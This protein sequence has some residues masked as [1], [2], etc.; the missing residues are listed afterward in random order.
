MGFSPNIVNL[1]SVALICLLPAVV[2]L[3]WRQGRPGPDGWGRVEMISIP[4]NL[5]A[6]ALVLFFVFQGQ[7][8]RAVAETVTVTDENGETVERTVVNGA[9]RRH[10]MLFYL[11]NEGPAGD[12]WLRQGFTVAIGTDL[13]QNPGLDTEQPLQRVADL[14]QMGFETGLDLPRPLQRKIAQDAHAPFF[15]AG[16]FRREGQDL[17]VNIVLHDTDKGTILAEHQASGPDFFAL[18]DGITV[19]LMDHLDLPAY[20]LETIPDQPVAD[21]TTDNLEAFREFVQAIVLITHEGRWEEAGDAIKRAVELDPTFALAHFMAFGIHFTNGDVEAAETASQE[22]MKHLYRVSERSQYQIKALYYHNVKSDPDKSMA[23]LEMWE[24]LYPYDVAAQMQ[25]VQFATM[26]G[27][28][29]RALVAY[30]RILEI[31]PS[32]HQFLQEAANLLR[33]EGRFA[34]AEEK[35]LRYAELYPG[36]VRSYARLVDLYEDMGELDKA[37]E[38]AE[39]SL[40]IEPDDQATMLQLAGLEKRLGHFAEMERILTQVL[41]S[42]PVG[43]V[44]ADAL[45]A[46]ANLQGL[47]GQWGTARA[48]YVQ[49]KEVASRAMIN[50]T[51][52]M[53]GYAFN[54]SSLATAETAPEILAEFDA[55]ARD[56]TPPNDQILGMCRAQVRLQQGLLDQALVDLAETEQL[57]ETYKLERL[58]V[59]SLMVRG[60]VAEQRGQYDEAVDSLQQAIELA[61]TGRRTTIFLGRALRKA[62]R[63]DDARETLEKLLAGYPGNPDA[64]MQMGL[65]LRAMGQREQGEKYLRQAAETW[66][67]ADADHPGAMELR[68]LG[69]G[70]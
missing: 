30:D 68:E 46:W 34:E 54:L 70:I 10:I 28:M 2:V 63:L 6:A 47:R 59:I 5:V 53:M 32:R 64:Q 3:A 62:G 4:A 49:W 38:A 8:F 66:R 19:F 25:I 56:L 52:A 36:E 58:R 15:V 1:L 69:F 22:S 61:P 21:L 24:R 44:H 29:D 41:D 31:D 67:D 9:Y 14:R 20:L 55:M 42:D 27:D 40:L 11:N 50:P 17:V 33:A 35:L 18:V 7:D 60:Q 23:V 48:T 57:I 51:Q 43:M 45:E 16:S 12:D 65:T 37:K 39:K 26:R 13:N